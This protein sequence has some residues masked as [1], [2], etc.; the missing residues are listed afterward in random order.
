MDKARMKLHYD[1]ASDIIYMVIKEGKI[2]DTVEA[3]TDIFLEIAEDNS[4]AGIEIWAASKNIL[5]P[6]AREMA[7]KLKKRLAATASP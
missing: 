4:V 1:P 5:E 2:K 3:D 7:A 6:L